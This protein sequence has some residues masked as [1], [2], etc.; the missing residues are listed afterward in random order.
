MTSSRDMVCLGPVGVMKSWFANHRPRLRYQKQIRLLIVPY[1][2][3][4]LVLMVLPALAPG[5]AVASTEHGGV[6]PR[7]RCGR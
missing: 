6:R 5:V 2:V 1:L 4:S 3:G 7:G